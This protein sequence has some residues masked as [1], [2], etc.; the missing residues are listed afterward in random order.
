MIIFL[1]GSINSGKSTVAKILATNI[2]NVALL[3]I[4]A[5]RSMIEWMPIEQAVSINLQNTI[6][7]VKNYC[8][9]NLNVIVPYPLSKQNYDHII[10]ELKN[11]DTDIYIFTLSPEL[12]KIITNRG[13]RKLNN[14]EIERIKYHYNIGINNPSFGEIIDN[15]RQTPEETSE[16]ILNKIKSINN[17]KTK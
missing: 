13:S 17:K 2:T 14:A 16:I 10:G 15:T 7:L 11:V 8:E 1:S 5:L 12:E 3:E 6:S 4:D 9:N